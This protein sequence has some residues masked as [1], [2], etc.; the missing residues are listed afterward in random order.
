MIHGIEK[1]VVSE[2]ENERMR[3]GWDETYGERES[4]SVRMHKSERIGVWEDTWTYLK[5][6][7]IPYDQFRR[8]DEIDGS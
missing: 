6:D 4:K 2:E 7:D 3:D 5:Y 1:G 8:C